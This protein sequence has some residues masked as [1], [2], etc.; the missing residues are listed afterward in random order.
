MCEVKQVWLRVNLPAGPYLP[1]RQGAARKPQ[2]SPD[3]TV[4]AAAAALATEGRVGMGRDD[5]AAAA[6]SDET[7]AVECGVGFVDLERNNL[8]VQVFLL[9]VTK[10]GKPTDQLAP[11]IDLRKFVTPYRRSGSDLLV[12]KDLSALGA[13]NELGSGVSGSEGRVGLL[14]VVGPVR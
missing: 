3:G 11:R 10:D 6:A 13:C 12:V 1:S 4:G 5:R 9:G 14:A 2:D 8:F 7:A